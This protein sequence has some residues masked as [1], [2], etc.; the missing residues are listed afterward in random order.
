M[1]PT[2]KPLVVGIAGI[3][4]AGKSTVA[5]VFEEMGARVV[6]ADALGKEM[7]DD[8]AIRGSLVEAFGA[9]ITD[10]SG[11]IDP[12]KLGKAAFQSETSART[13]DGITRDALVARIRAR[14]GEL[15]AS[16]DV[17]VVDAALLPEWGAEAWLDILVVVDSEEGR[18]M[19]RLAGRSRF[20]QADVRRRMGHQ[21]GR[22]AKAGR[23]DIII[24][25][26]GT[27]EELK[28]RASG[29]FRKLLSRDRGPL[30]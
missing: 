30:A 29:V 17:V 15:G 6:D 27:L 18:A 2:S 16:S 7:L 11:K 13:L 4:G 22:A 8:P 10:P 25:N 1:K 19:E 3:M 12:A 9:K 14:I 24:P 23:A 21:L 28:T 5:A 26:Y 20:D